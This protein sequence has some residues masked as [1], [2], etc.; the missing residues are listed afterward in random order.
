MNLVEKKKCPLAK[1]KLHQF[2][3]KCVR[4][5]SRNVL[6][7]LL[8]L[9]LWFNNLSKVSIIHDNNP[10]TPLKIDGFIKLG[11]N[12]KYHLDSFS[13]DCEYFNLRCNNIIAYL[14]DILFSLLCA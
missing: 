3:K 1:I 6:S 14:R 8:P 11:M 13:R 9:W 2:P 5:W 12:I 7:I 4:K 10:P